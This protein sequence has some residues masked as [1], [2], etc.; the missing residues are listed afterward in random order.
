MSSEA[1]LLL[2]TNKYNKAQLTLTDCASI[3]W[4]LYKTYRDE[5]TFKV[6]C[7]ITY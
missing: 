3:P 7:N 1:R 4:F 6:I 5:S 2:E